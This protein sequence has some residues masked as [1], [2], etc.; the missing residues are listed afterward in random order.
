MAQAQ[1]NL[2]GYRSGRVLAV[3]ACLLLLGGALVKFGFVIFHAL[4]LG[5]LLAGGLETVRNEEE[6][7]TTVLLQAPLLISNFVIYLATIVFFLLWLY[8]AF[9]NLRPLG[10]QRLD[11]S[12]GWAVGSFFIPFLNLVRPY[13]AARELW[14]WSQPLGIGPERMT[15][16]PSTSAPLVGWWWGL[17]LVSNFTSNAYWKLSDNTEAA[18]ALPWL[19]LVAD[20]TTIA[21]AALA[22]MMIWSIDR[23]QTEKSQQLAISGASFEQPPPPPPPFGAETLRLS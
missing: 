7:S 2:Y 14:R 5:G 16:G 23:M 6:V 3:L 1:A 9:S 10:A 19:G 22:I 21:A 8:R 20:F 15:F 18:A 13:K 11:N 12:A 4:Q 17:W